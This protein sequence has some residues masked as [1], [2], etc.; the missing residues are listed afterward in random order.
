MFIKCKRAPKTKRFECCTWCKFPGG[1][2]ASTNWPTNWTYYLCYYIVFVANFAGDVIICH[3]QT[4]AVRLPHFCFSFCLCYFE[5]DHGGIDEVHQF[6]S[7]FLPNKTLILFL[8]RY[9]EKQEW[10]ER[11]VLFSHLYVVSKHHS[12]SRPLDF[13]ELSAIFR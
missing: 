12:Y 13:A 8:C 4:L 1:K 9:R 11:F 10:F 2:K 6:S 3:G 5:T 7:D